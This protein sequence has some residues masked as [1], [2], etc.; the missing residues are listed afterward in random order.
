MVIYTVLP[1]FKMPVK[2]Y[3]ILIAVLDELPVST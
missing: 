3:V 1:V 2:R